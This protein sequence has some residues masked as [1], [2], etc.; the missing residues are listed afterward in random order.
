MPPEAGADANAA[1][2]YQNQ[3][4]TLSDV[5]KNATETQSRTISLC[6]S[7][8][9]RAASTFCAASSTIP[10]AYGRHPR[11][12]RPHS[13][14]ESRSLVHQLTPL[15][16]QA[17]EEPAGLSYQPLRRQLYLTF[18]KSYTEKV[19]GTPCEEINA[20]WGAQRIK[21]LSLTTAVKHFFKKT[22]GK[23]RRASH[24]KGPT[25]R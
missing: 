12:A 6:L 4:R 23:K 11:Q 8:R 25:P 3:T 14:G 10:Y 21:G 9:A 17:R 19:W 5:A 24:R 16:D 22:F 2:S 15:A 13:H 1:I 20:E 18:F 7:V